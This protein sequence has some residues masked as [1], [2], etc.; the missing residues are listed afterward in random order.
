MIQLYNGSP[1]NL[2]QFISSYELLISTFDEINDVNLKLNLIK[3]LRSKS[4]D[5]I[6]LLVASST[7]L[8]DWISIKKCFNRVFW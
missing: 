2:T 3:V 5:R 1:N 8:K 6:N 4:I 7:E